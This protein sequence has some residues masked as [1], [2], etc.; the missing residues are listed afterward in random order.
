MTSSQPLYT[1]K[2]YNTLDPDF[3]M[4]ITP[5]FEFS[6]NLTTVEQV[7][8]YYIDNKSI[9]T[10]NREQLINNHNFNHEVYYRLY[11]SNILNDTTYIE[12]SVRSQVLP[13]TERLSIIHWDR[14]GIHNLNFQT[15]NI[16]SNFNPFLYRTMHQITGDYTPEN[17]YF[18]YLDRKEAGLENV[19]VGNINELT[20]HIRC[21]VTF[22]LDKLYVDEDVN[23]REDLVVHRNAYILGNLAANANGISVNGGTIEVDNRFGDIKNLFDYTYL[24][25]NSLNIGDFSIQSNLV[26]S[27]HFLQFKGG[28]INIENSL[29]VDDS[30]LIG[31]GLTFDDSFSLQTQKNI[32]VAGTVTSSDKRSKENINLTNSK[33]CLEKIKQVK[34]S[35]FNFKNKTESV[36][37][38]GVIAQEIKQIFPNIV[39]ETVSFLPTIMKYFTPTSKNTIVLESIEDINIGDTLLIKDKNNKHIYTKVIDVDNMKIKLNIDELNINEQYL[40]FGKE[41]KDSLSV[42]YTQLFCYLLS[43]VQE[44]A[45]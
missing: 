5:E 7:Y 38:S 36:V 16:D 8:Q 17:L 19:V 4:Y 40:L 14:Y 25:S 31:S 6:C 18:D 9:T 32:K 24:T 42:D 28:N 13:D 12:D 22:G 3:Y 41:I 39:N 26:N 29:L 27:D 45:K 35:E 15:V 2:S 11:S 23:I 34:I 20:Y 1:N 43:A 33:E 37:S 10:L 30:V 21:N 44:L